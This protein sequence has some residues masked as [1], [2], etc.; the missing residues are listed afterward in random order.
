VYQYFDMQDEITVVDFYLVLS[1]E[2]FLA[3]LS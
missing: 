1:I 2:Q 3:F